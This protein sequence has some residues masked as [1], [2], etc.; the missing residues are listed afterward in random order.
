MRQLIIAIIIALLA[1][2][3]ALQNADPVTVKL[4]LWDLPN[5]SL[6][7]LLL[8]TLV[9]GIVSS[10]LFMTSSVYNKNKIISTQKKR[11]LELEKEISLKSNN[12]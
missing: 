5:T 7:L 8:I 6:A 1:V 11:I 9:I 10:L 2:I 12:I 3:F 4:F